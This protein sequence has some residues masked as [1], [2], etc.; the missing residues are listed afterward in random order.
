M[1]PDDIVLTLCK[2]DRWIMD[3][4]PL[5]EVSIADLNK[6]AETWDI[7]IEVKPDAENVGGVTLFGKKFGNHDQDINFKAYYS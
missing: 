6:T 4:D 3:G 1:G 2:N 5:S 7:R